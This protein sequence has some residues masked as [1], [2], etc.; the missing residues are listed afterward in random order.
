MV[1]VSNNYYSY[2]QNIVSSF[3]CFVGLLFLI[4]EIVSSLLTNYTLSN[5]CPNARVVQ[6]EAV[7]KI[8]DQS[9]E[10]TK[11]NRFEGTY[12]YAISGTQVTW[13]FQIY[14]KI[15][16]ILQSTLLTILLASL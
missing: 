15:T 14:F 11:T 4:V 6:V 12:K 1:V 3:V 7:T 10:K 8:S 16:Y 2:I 13:Y 9:F 5:L